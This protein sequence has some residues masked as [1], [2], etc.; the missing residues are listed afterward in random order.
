MAPSLLAWPATT[1]EAS[2][3]WRVIASVGFVIVYVLLTL[4]FRLIQ[5]DEIRSILQ[6]L[7]GRGEGSERVGLPLE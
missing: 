4:C 7:L 5:R 2:F 6:K 3:S 1:W